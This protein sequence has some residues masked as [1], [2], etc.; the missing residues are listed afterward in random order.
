MLI[1]CE[2][3]RALFSLQDGVATAGARIPVQCGR[4]LAVFEAAGFSKA[5]PPAPPE[6]LAPPGPE[7]VAPT[8]T[9]ALAVVPEPVAADLPP[10]TEPRQQESRAW[11]PR[12]LAGVTA[13]VLVLA[14]A[15]GI[16]ISRRLS[17]LPS[18]AAA[19]V[20][21]GRTKMLRDD[22]RSLDEAVR[23]F[24]EAAR[25]APGEAV[26]E[27]ERGFALL[28]QAAAH[29]DLAERVGSP[30]R[31]EEAKTASRFVQQGG[32]A[33]KQAL[34]ENGQEPAALRAVALLEALTGA[35]DQAA[36]HA[37]AAEQGAPK[38]VWVLYAKAAAARAARA[39]DR[40]AAA[41]LQLRDTEPKLLRA[42]VDLAAVSIDRRDHAA[43]RDA[44][45]RVLRENPAHERARRLL[46]LLSAAAP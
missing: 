2:R 5:P 42:Q 8:P 33:A 45:Q 10:A 40:A 20:E 25:I 41:L 26:P 1:R 9:P 22:A 39:Q 31:E 32:G 24:T 4:C 44:L 6:A 7:P 14:I 27:A 29:K 36:Q 11:P 13:L 23:L 17:A 3:C 43:A 18:D 30:E 19:K 34:A 35:A 28:L 15:I 12:L 37:A 21:E 46:A 16:S 38:D